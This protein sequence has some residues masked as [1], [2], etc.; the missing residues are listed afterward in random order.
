[1]GSTTHIVDEAGQVQNRYEYDAWGNIT[2][3]EEAVPN[4]FKY[5]GQQLD[6]VTQQYYLRARFYNPVIARFTQEDT[7]RGDGLNLYAYCANNPV[8]YADPTGYKKSSVWGTDD[9][10]RTTYTD[11]S[12]NIYK[13]DAK[14][15]WHDSSGT[16]CPN[17]TGQNRP[18]SPKAPTTN[19]S[20]TAGQIGRRGE[21]I[22]TEML[23]QN[24]WEIITPIKN[25]SDNGTDIVA[26]SSDGRLGFFEV[27][28]TDGGEIGVLSQ[29]QSD[30]D[31]FVRDVLTNAAYKKGRYQ[32][33]SDAISQ[34]AQQILKEYD[35]R[36]WDVTGSVI[37][38]DISNEEVYISRWNR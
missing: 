37:G 4:R 34:V 16:F 20:P 7:Y 28:S 27:K 35:A 10:G 6:P 30:M 8:Y 38:V 22:A 29:R 9:K 24:G 17:P 15:N 31:F 25:G 12:G 3:Q 5:T 33:I 18:S 23:R 26:R 32:S 14:G 19:A 2:V 36:P 13:Q 1:M 21:E 11:A